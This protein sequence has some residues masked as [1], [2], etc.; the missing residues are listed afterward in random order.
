MAVRTGGKIQNLATRRGRREAGGT[1]DFGVLTDV[2]E[3]HEGTWPPGLGR[4]DFAEGLAAAFAVEYCGWR[5]WRDGVDGGVVEGK[6]A[7]IAIA[8]FD[9]IGDTFPARVL[10]S[11]FTGVVS[12]IDLRP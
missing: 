9:A 7:H 3:V 11:G 8:D 6:F 10:E 2:L 1:Q 4:G 5:D 12:L